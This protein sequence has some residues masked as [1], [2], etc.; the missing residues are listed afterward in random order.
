[1]LLEF[2]AW[3]SPPLDFSR[4]PITKK[5]RKKNEKNN[6]NNNKNKKT[7]I[8]KKIDERPPLSR[9]YKWQIYNLFFISKTFH[10]DPFR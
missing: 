2:L 1:M 5:K 6:N 3:D 7:E 9:Y 8:Q 10:R 4:T